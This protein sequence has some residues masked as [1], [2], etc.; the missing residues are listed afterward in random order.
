MPVL[1]EKTYELH[2]VAL[3]HVNSR[4][5]IAEPNRAFQVSAAAGGAAGDERS[6][7]E[8]LVGK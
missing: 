5:L 3:L 2:C 1:H 7:F 4:R 8:H 6:V